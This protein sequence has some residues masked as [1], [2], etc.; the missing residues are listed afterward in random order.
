LRHFLIITLLTGIQTISFAQKPVVPEHQ[1]KAIFLFNFIQFVEWP[2][3]AFESVDS[4]I[5]IGILGENPF[6]GYLNEVLAGEVVNGRS[7][8]VK[9]FNNVDELDTS[10]ILYIHNPPTGDYKK[11]FAKIDRRNVL[12]ISDDPNFI[13]EGG[14]IRFVNVDKRIQL[15]INPE[16]AK[17]ANLTISSKLL[18]LA[19]IVAVNE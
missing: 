11:L 15:Q 6:G 19:E 16:A 5:V 7:V 13:K 1:I 2:S 9:R 14:M 12:T 4:P 3:Q 18:R 8:I 10:H 17:K